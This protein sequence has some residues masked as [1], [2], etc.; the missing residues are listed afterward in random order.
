MGRPPR[1]DW[2]VVARCTFGHPTVIA[3]SPLIEGRV[4]FPTTFWLTCP[5]LVTGAHQLESA[6]VHARWAERIAQDDALRERAIAADESYRAAR[7]VEGG[8]DDPC[9][10]VGVAGQ[11]DPLVVKC[12]H[13]RLAAFLAGVDDPVGAAIAAELGDPARACTEPRCLGDATGVSPDWYDRDMEERADMHDANAGGADARV[14]RIAAIDIGTVT[15]RVLVADTDGRTVSEVLRNTV[16]THLG[17]G[18]HASG[19]LSEAGIERVSA[20]VAVFARRAAELGAEQTVAIATS[21]ARDA[22]NSNVLVAALAAEGVSLSVIPGSLEARLAFIGAT[23]GI[24]GDG[25]LIADLGGGSTE[26]VFGSARVTN[27]GGSADID[28]ARS[29]DVGARRVLDMFLASDPPDPRELQAAEAWVAA[30]MR[31]FFTGLHERPRMFITLAGTGTTLSAIWQGLAVYDSSRVHGS[32]LTGGEVAD[33]RARLAAMTVSQ[34]RDV[35][36]M[37][38][39]RADVIVA[40]AL[41]LETIMALAGADETVVSEHDILYG[42]TLAGARGELA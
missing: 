40:G 35:V 32:I 29:L 23:Y 19:L 10:A 5:R 1:G 38:P 7:R 36:G 6:G 25:I 15:S 17:E 42:I 22:A 28:A 2:R 8:G 11:R 20:A 3:V 24:D 14:R 4:P 21:A 27:A 9:A 34:R 39:A 31:P 12:L 16:V 13:A 33:L 41:I 18:L 26:L 30:Q 37:D